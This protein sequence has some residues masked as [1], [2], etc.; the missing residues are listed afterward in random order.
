[1][2]RKTINRQIKKEMLK[3]H[4]FG[5]F[6]QKIMKLLL[7][8]GKCIPIEINKQI[9]VHGKRRPMLNCSARIL[10]TVLKLSAFT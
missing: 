8:S 5:P 4:L 2:E 9:K 7:Y 1:M 3:P 10:I 6:Q